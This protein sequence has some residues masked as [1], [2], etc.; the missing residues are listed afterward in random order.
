MKLG[1]TVTVVV[2]AVTVLFALAGWLIDLSARHF[3]RP[4]GQKER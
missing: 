2:L 4:Q 1:L 3:D